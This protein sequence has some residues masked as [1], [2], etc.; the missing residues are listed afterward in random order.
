MVGARSRG[1]RLGY[2]QLTKG[3]WRV[4]S[5]PLALPSRRDLTAVS[6]PQP[7]KG[8]HGLKQKHCS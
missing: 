1:R 5:R 2:H 7:S 4:I 8:K 3:Q 6:E